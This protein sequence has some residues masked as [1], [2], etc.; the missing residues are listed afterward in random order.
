MQLQ[1]YFIGFGLTCLVRIAMSAINSTN[2]LFSS[3]SPT[4]AKFNS[5]LNNQTALFQ[6]S[7]NYALRIIKAVYL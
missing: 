1:K 6:V 7:F 2:S 3:V 4:T 5:T